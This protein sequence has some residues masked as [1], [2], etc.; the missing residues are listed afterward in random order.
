[1]TTGSYSQSWLEA[2]LNKYLNDKVYRGFPIQWRQLL[3]NCTVKSLGGKTSTDLVEATG[4]V[5]IPA[6]SDMGATDSSGNS[7]V[8]SPYIDEIS[9]ANSCLALFTDATSRILYHENGKAVDY[10]LRTPCPKGSSW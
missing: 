6:A 3:K 5:I 8:S 10:W 4:Y 2:D 7:L 9:P 1:M